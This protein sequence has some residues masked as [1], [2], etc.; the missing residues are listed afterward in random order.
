MTQTHEV[1][2]GDTLGKIAARYY[3]KA[4]LYK[5]LAAYNNIENVNVIRVGMK[6]KIPSETVLVKG[7][8]VPTPDAPPDHRDHGIV[9]PTGLNQIIKTFG[10]V[11]KHVGADGKPLASWEAAHMVRAQLPFT[12]PLS[13]A[14]SQVVK[15]LYCHRKLKDL[16]RTVF[17]EIVEEKLKSKVVSYGGCFEYRLKRGTHE[18]S[19]HSWGIAIDLNVK[20]NQVGTKGDMAPGIVAVFKRHGFNWGGDWSGRRCDPMHFQFCDGY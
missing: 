9:C 14:P 19:T 12:I 11:R 20:T 16:F 7:K 15:R 6:L 10:D 8:P 1:R 13:W 17:N 2:T 4:S 18:L 5:K 3:G